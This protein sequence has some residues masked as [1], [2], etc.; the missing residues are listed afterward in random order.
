MLSFFRKLKSFFS[1]AR[2]S[3]VR[4]IVGSVY[5][6]VEFIAKMTPTKADDEILRCAN[7]LG[8]YEFLS[9]SPEDAGAALKELAI[10]AA[11]KKF[12][13]IPVE[14][15]ARAV[16]AAYQEMKAKQAL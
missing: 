11:Q 8:V 7:A 12:K 1:P 16:E 2:I 10:K 4:G 3:A 9:A 14:V 6:I 15:L 13:D 5:P